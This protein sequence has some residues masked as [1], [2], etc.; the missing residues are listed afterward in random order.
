MRECAEA[1]VYDG[2]HLGMH[3]A[4]ARH[5]AMYGLKPVGSHRE[6]AHEMLGPL[7]VSCDVCSGDS[8][9]TNYDEE[10]WSVCPR[11]QGLG[12]VW[13]VPASKIAAAREPDVRDRH[14]VE[15]QPRSSA[16]RFSESS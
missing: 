11:C 8:L 14:I 9:V 15:R 3:E 10:T 5:Q 2:W 6:L 16:I 4:M 12:F 13:T 7:C 1:Y